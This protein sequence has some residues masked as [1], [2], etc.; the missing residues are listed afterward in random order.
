MSVVTTQQAQ[1]SELTAAAEEE[2]LRTIAELPPAWGKMC[3]AK[4]STHFFWAHNGESRNGWV[5]LCANGVL[6]TSWCE[7]SWQKTSQ[8]DVLDMKFGSSHHICHL[9]GDPP[10]SFIVEKK[11]LARNNQDNYRPGAP[12]S[13]G[14]ICHQSECRKRG[15]VS[16][17]RDSSTAP[18]RRNKDAIQDVDL[19]TGES[20]SQKDLTFDGF[21]DAWTS[22][23]ESRKRLKTEDLAKAMEEVNVQTLQDTK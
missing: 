1:S 13:A 9:R 18:R 8:P 7:G 21:Y 20:F 19:A 15:V 16:R 17:Y 4:G 6:E 3:K 12:K 11:M 5:H 14:W 10:S 2:F 22:W 23:Q